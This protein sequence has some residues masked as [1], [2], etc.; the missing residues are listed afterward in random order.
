MTEYTV[1]IA[2]WLRAFE[3]FAVEAASDQDRRI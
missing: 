2:F 3:G 1:K